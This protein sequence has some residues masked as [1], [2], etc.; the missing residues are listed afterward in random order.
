MG[1]SPSQMHIF[2][3]E[4]EKSSIKDYFY[5]VWEMRLWLWQSYDMLVF[6]H[7]QTFIGLDWKDAQ[8][9]ASSEI[10]PSGGLFFS[11]KLRIKVL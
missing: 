1:L 8:W 6:D 7:C 5:E 11:F 3:A 2:H 4:Q 9:R 10:P